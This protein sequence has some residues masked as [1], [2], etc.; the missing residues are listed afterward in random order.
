MALPVQSVLLLCT[1]CFIFADAIV[2]KWCYDES[3]TNPCKSLENENDIKCVPAPNIFRCMELV[4]TGTADVLLVTDTQLYPAGKIG[5]K[6]LLQIVHNNTGDYRYKAVAVV[7]ANG[8]IKKLTDLKNAKSCHTG[9]GKTTGWTT[10]VSNLIEMGI[11]SPLKDCYSSTENVAELFMASCVPGAME[12]RYNPLDRNPV[13]LCSLC[14]NKTATCSRTDGYAGY[15]GAKKCLESTDADIAFVKHETMLNSDKTKYKLFCPDGKLM[16]LDQYHDCNWAVRPSDTIVVS[17]KVSDKTSISNSLKR[18]LASLIH[19]FNWT[20]VKELQDT[21]SKGYSEIMGKG[22][23]NTFEHYHNCKENLRWCVISDHE[24]KKCTDLKLAFMAKRA[25][26]KLECIKVKDQYECMTAIE[27]N[28]A[29]FVVLDGGDISTAIN[30][31]NLEPVIAEDY[32]IETATYFAVAVAKRDANFN[33]KQLKGKKSCHTG[34]GKTSGWKAPIS[35]LIKNNILPKGHS[36]PEEVGKFF[37][38]S[39]VPGALDP[40]YNPEGHNPK[41]LCAL[42]PNNGTDCQRNSENKYYDYSG[43]FRCLVET[44][45]DVAFVKHTTVPEST[46]G[47]GNEMWERSLKSNNYKLLCKDG[48][49]ASVSEWRSCHLAKVP[50][51]AIVVR[52]GNRNFG[53]LLFRVFN[54]FDLSDKNSL[55]LLFTSDKGKNFLFKDSTKGLIHIADPHKYLG[56]DYL[57]IVKVFGTKLHVCSGSSRTTTAL[58]L[59]L[60][61][62]LNYLA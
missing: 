46:D 12:K 56:D 60:F 43:A 21:G 19:S 29:D 25:T 24:L 49:A 48:T 34:I 33:I 39:C 27:Q 23:K 28:K 9:A 16:G 7:K 61:T 2:V 10:P 15:E 40:Q 47:N 57:E 17:P 42:C 30:N 11:I 44:S 52:K 14:Q 18:M 8:K 53:D 45:A 35:Y 62:L 6:P 38:A 20:N 13:R 50:A 22:F 5:L 37:S 32:G 1:F 51:H 31:C 26:N 58:I 36:I 59:V 55:K 3:N 4:K 41:S 54:N